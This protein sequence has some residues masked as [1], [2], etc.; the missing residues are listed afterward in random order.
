MAVREACAT[1]GSAGAYQAL[2]QVLPLLSVA[3]NENEIGGSGLD[4]EGHAAETRKGKHV[5]NGEEFNLLYG[6]LLPETVSAVL[7]QLGAN[8]GGSILELGMGTGKVA[9]QA[10]LQCPNA[11]QI[12]GVELSS[13]RYELS[14]A[15]AR[16]LA[17]SCGNRFSSRTA[18]AGAIE[19]LLKGIDGVSRGHMLRETASDRCLWLL[20]G[21]L[22]ALGGAIEEAKAIFMNLRLPPAVRTRAYGA[23]NR[24]PNGCRIFSLENLT[25]EWTLPE[26]AVLHAESEGYA[27]GDTDLY[28]TSWCDSGFPFYIFDV[29]RS[30]KPSITK[31]TA[32][33]VVKELYSQGFF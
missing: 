10:F 7:E 5:I 13:A 4:L 33:E 25:W 23:L 8:V 28:A 30:R 9:F 29:D 21:D 26:P 17:S 3:F 1:V 16:R 19:G 12:V 20:E 2:D 27:L 24:A 14:V 31:D 18:D 11:R 6:E 32:I 15:A 22:T